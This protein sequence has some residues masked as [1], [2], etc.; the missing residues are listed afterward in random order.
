MIEMAADDKWLLPKWSKR[1]QMRNGCG[2]NDWNGCRWKSAAGK[3]DDRN[4]CRWDMAAGKNDW[5]DCRW[6]MAAGKM[7]DMAADEKWLQANRTETAADEKWL[8]AKWLTQLQMRNGSR[9]TKLKQLQMRNGCRQ[10]DWNGCRWEMAAGKRDDWT[11]ADVKWLQA[12][13]MT[14]MA[15]ESGYSIMQIQNPIGYRKWL[16]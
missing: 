12:K 3:G 10:N 5:K 2:Q 4:G 6:Q 8:L 9:Q 11:A 14:E 15:A 1:L 13:A 7:T 16:R